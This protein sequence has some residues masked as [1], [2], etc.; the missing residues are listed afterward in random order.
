MKKAE[1]FKD[2]KNGVYPFT[3][4]PGPIETTYT[5]NV[6]FPTA[7]PYGG[8]PQ[9]GAYGH[10]G[11]AAPMAVPVAQSAPVPGQ[12]LPNEWTQQEIMQPKP[13]TAAPS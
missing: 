1:Y 4:P 12:A 8:Y 2:A 5:N 9:Y 7:V 6:P 13:M 11:Y 10:P 3:K